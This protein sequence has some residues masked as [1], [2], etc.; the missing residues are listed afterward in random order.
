MALV[1]AVR[2]IGWRTP[3]FPVL[4]PVESVEQILSAEAAQGGGDFA[5]LFGF[6]PKEEHALAQLFGRRLRREYGV[7]GVR[8]VAAV[9]CLRAYGHRR[10]RKVLRRWR[11][12][13]LDEVEADGAARFRDIF[14]G[15]IRV[16]AT[17]G[18]LDQFDCKKERQTDPSFS[19]RGRIFR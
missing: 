18:F 1:I 12:G 11:C 8:V 5:A 19:S 13:F 16:A 14:Q 6:I 7:E 10:G 17:A 2:C 4:F 3:L 15:E 9:P